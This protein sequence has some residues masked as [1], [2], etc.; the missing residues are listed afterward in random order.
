[1]SE[2]MNFKPVAV[3][4]AAGFFTNDTCFMLRIAMPAS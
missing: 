2:L 4:N 1:M 3:S